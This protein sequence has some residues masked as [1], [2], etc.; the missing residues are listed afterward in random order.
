MFSAVYPQAVRI[1]GAATNGMDI[2]A[3]DLTVFIEYQPPGTVF[4]R[5]IFSYLPGFF[6]EIAGVQNLGTISSS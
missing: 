6:H 3:L 5:T 1:C 4:L 2:F